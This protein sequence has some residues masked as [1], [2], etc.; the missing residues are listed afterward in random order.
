MRTQADQWREQI[1]KAEANESDL[2]VR[3]H[4]K[5]AAVEIMQEK[6]HLRLQACE[7][8]LDQ[9]VDDQAG[10]LDIYMDLSPELCQAAGYD[11]KEQEDESA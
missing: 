5:E 3:K 7:E 4:M 11:P 10:L 1:D 9:M 8:L 6:E 2:A